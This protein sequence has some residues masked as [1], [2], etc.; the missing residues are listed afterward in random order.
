MRRRVRIL[1]GVPGWYGTIQHGPVQESGIRGHRVTMPTFELA[2]NPVINLTNIRERRFNLIDRA[3][4]LQ[5][6][7]AQDTN[8][9][10]VLERV[11]PEGDGEPNP[12]QED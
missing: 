6:N 9:F 11:V 8:V 10:A 2:S 4:E 5:S 3:Q 7:M 12:L 1:R